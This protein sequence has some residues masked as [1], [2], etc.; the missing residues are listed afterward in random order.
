MTPHDSPILPPHGGYEDLR[1]YQKARLVY[2][3][4]V[5]FCDRFVPVRDRT[6]DQMIQAARSGKQ[7]IVEGNQVSATS[8]ATE[9]RLVSVARGSLE[10][11]LE[12][13]RDFLR[14]RGLPLWPAG[15]PEALA[16]RRQGA[17]VATH[18][19]ALLERVRSSPPAEAANVL[20]CLVHQANFLLDRQ[21]REVTE[22]FRHEGGFHERLSRVRRAARGAA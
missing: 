22:R 13:Y 14:S 21:L 1:S 16:V 10:E 8:R 6:R 11:L 19:H 15:C 7:N 5:I 9:I 4:T 2:D 18:G 12:D 3:A 17:D 20:V